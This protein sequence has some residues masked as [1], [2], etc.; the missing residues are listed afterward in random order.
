MFG[1]Q[2]LD[3]L[4]EPGVGLWLKSQHMEVPKNEICEVQEEMVPSDI[5]IDQGM[6]KVPGQ[7]RTQVALKRLVGVRLPGKGSGYSRLYRCSQDGYFVHRHS[8]LYISNEVPPLP[9]RKHREAS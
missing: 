2:N 6:S 4:R 7:G 3:G 5:A 8:G 9:G 1:Q